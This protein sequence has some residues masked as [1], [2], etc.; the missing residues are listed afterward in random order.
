MPP[1]LSQLVNRCTSLRAHVKLTSMVYSHSS[2]H[3]GNSLIMFYSSGNHMSSP[4]PGSITYIYEEAGSLAF[5]VQRQCTVPDDRNNADV[6]AAYPH[7]P[8]KL[9]SS[10]FSKTLESVQIGW[11]VGHYAWWVLE[12]GIAV[13]LSLSRVGTLF[14]VMQLC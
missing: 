9:Y 7:F 6:F 12:E 11:I 2:A 14:S 13:V 8:A 1:D 4:V 5:A 3:F 10:M